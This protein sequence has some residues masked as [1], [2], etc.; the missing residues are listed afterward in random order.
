MKKAIFNLVLRSYELEKINKLVNINMYI[1]KGGNF[2]MSVK[3]KKIPTKTKLNFRK[4]FLEFNPIKNK[5]KIM[6][7][8]KPISEL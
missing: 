1:I 5:L 7:E 3:V 4:F 6:T 8:K 2:T